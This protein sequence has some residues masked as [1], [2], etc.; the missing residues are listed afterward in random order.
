[1]P[2]HTAFPAP[3]PALL[4][5]CMLLAGA[6]GICG[7]ME[8]STPPPA[9]QDST[10]VPA[11]AWRID[12][13]VIVV[14]NL[15]SAMG[16]YADSGFTVVPGGTHGD[17]STQNALITFEDGSYLEIFA[18]V[19]PALEESMKT[20][21]ST[22]TFEAD[23]TGENAMDARFMHHLGE[24]A[25]LRDFA[26]WYPGINLS[27]SRQD[28][29]RQGFALD[30][31]IPM[32]RTRPDGIDVRWQVSV[33]VSADSGALPFLISDDTPRVYRVPGGNA[34]V[35]PN[36]AAGIERIVIAT[37]D[38][39]NVTRWYD[40]V[41]AGREKSVSGMATTYRLDGSEIIVQGVTTPE[42]DGPVEIVLNT[43]KGIPI[44]LNGRI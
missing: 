37:R 18:A 33:P 20:L 8:F 13:A 26:I 35:H 4:I 29:G 7:C 10:P 23:I 27:T 11:P 21:V 36:H 39:V 31:P 38:P 32:S 40:T 22:G 24:G 41:L 6:A 25:G 12:H 3:V 17:G 44:R 34:T 30:G 16:R 42:Q 19:D 28:A 14:D 5:L 15:S 1:M 9:E 43:G 2:A